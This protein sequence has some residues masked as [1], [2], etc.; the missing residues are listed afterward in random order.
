[1]RG[2]DCTIDAAGLICRSVSLLPLS[3]ANSSHSGVAI[4]AS[5]A[6]VWVQ[7]FCFVDPDDETQFKQLGRVFAATIDLT[8]P[9]GDVLPVIESSN[10]AKAATA[11]LRIPLQVEELGSRAVRCACVGIA[12]LRL[13]R[14][15]QFRAV[16][17]SISWV[18]SFS[19]VWLT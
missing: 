15:H 13:S 17:K 6:K 12:S 10:E 3:G 7:M 8:S 14:M 19:R 2:Q 9:W 18:F 4:A 11:A 5:T 1:M 16:L